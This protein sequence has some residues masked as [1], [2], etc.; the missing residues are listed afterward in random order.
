MQKTCVYWP[1]VWVLSSC[2]TS[3]QFTAASLSL[4]RVMCLL[5]RATRWRLARMWPTSISSYCSHS[6]HCVELVATSLI[7][8]T[9][10]TTKFW[11][12]TLRPSPGI[13]AELRECLVFLW[14]VLEGLVSCD[15]SP[16][17]MAAGHLFAC[18]VS[19]GEFL[20]IHMKKTVIYHKQNCN[21]YELLQNLSA[22]PMLSLYIQKFKDFCVVIHTWYH[23][24]PIIMIMLESGCST[25]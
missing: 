9:T 10:T 16:N 25:K 15:F 14:P 18:L 6:R 3:S 22:I 21:T 11:V 17:L 8:G 13:N 12:W 20:A 5:E 19:G 4:S 7:V 1:D 2:H 24:S 23:D